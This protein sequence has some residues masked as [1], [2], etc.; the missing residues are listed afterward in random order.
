MNPFTYTISS[1][2]NLVDFA[3][4]VTLDV[5]P[6]YGE[7]TEYELKCTNFLLTASEITNMSEYALL[8]VDDWAENGYCQ[9]LGSNQL[10]VC[11]F[12]TNIAKNQILNESIF[13]VKN[14]RQRRTVRF[15]FYD[16]MLKALPNTVSGVLATWLLTFIVTPIK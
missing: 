4:D 3:N 7:Y 2:T 5:G 9:G 14:M 6:F 8:V 13:T 16:N 11:S 12:R 1:T 15:R 10:I